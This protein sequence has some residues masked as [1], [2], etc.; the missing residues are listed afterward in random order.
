V[1]APVAIDDGY[2]Y[3]VRQSDLDFLQ[4]PEAAV[5]AW[6]ARS[7]PLGMSA[8]QFAHFLET[9]ER[10]FEADG[11]LTY[12]VR[13]Q[14]SAANFF[15]GHHKEMPWRREQMV[16]EFRKNRNRVPETFEIDLVE[17]SLSRQWPDL[18][19]PRRRPFD[20]MYR[21]GL[22][23]YPSDVDIQI[24]ADEVVDRARE[25]IAE[26]GVPADRLTTHSE[27]Y[28]FVRKDLLE[29]T[30]PSLHLWSMRASD[31]VG[32]NVTMAAFSD[33]G[34]PDTGSTLS[35]HFRDDDWLLLQR[36]F[37]T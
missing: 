18:S 15:S 12:D 34:P 9:L 7:C 37:T 10:A 29:D 11:I 30:C 17:E 4:I 2:G 26:L 32:R 27:H 20:A 14:G 16:E 8:P 23:R 3:V 13:L 31:V 22:D 36:R 28:A 1:A 24:S 35:A 21:L 25:R 33:G 6:H 19:R 5:D